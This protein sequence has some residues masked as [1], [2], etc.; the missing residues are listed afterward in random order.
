MFYS[1]I[2]VLVISTFIGTVAENSNKNSRFIERFDGE[3]SFLSEKWVKSLDSKYVDQPVKIKS[4]DAPL[5]GFENDKGVE[6][7]QEMKYYGFGTTFSKPFY[8][9]NGKELVLQYDLKI[10]ETLTCG[11]A[12]IKMPRSSDSFVMSQL[13]SQTPYTIM[14]GP[15][16]CGNNNKVHFIL[17]YQNPINLIWEEKHFNETIPAL[18][19]KKT[20]LYTLQIKDDNFFEIFIDKKLKKSGNLLT[21]MNP[22]INPLKEI[23][24]PNDFKPVNWI[25]EKQIED[26]N[27]LKPDDWDETEPRMIQDMNSIIPSDWL[28]NEPLK[29]SDPNAIKPDGWDDEEDGIFEANLIDNPICEKI[30]GCGEWKRPMIK[31]PAFKGIW[32]KP[33]IDNPAYIGQWTPRKIANSNY[34]YH[35]N[36][37]EH[38]ASMAGLAVEVWTINGGLRFDNFLVTDSLKDAFQFADETFVI[39]SNLENQIDEE[40]N[41]ELKK[42]ERMKR[43]SQEGA[44]FYDKALIYLGPYT[45]FIVANIIYMLPT[46][47]VMLLA[48]FYFLYSITKSSPP[49]KMKKNETKTEEKSVE[50]SEVKTEEE[51]EKEE[52]KKE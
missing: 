36:P 25:D 32:K 21:H 31:N 19:D 20:H 23:D 17:Q 22:P 13:N 43:A 51:E 9:K 14:F 27:A 47:L 10:Q 33:S 18:T 35:E 6:L 1:L 11:G 38:I 46:V 5:K 28:I 37:Y 16:K 7:T 42:N 12:Y 50:K 44:T 2:V 30:S 3:D 29:I 4:S 34:Y 15:D 45:D 49:K 41:K 40:Q 24:D 8:P 52:I 48:S 39:K 26:L